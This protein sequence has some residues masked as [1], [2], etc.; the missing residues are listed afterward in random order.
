MVYLLHSICE[1]VR[2]WAEGC[3]CHWWLRRQASSYNGDV[4]G[5]RGKCS[6][7]ATQLDR[8]RRVALQFPSG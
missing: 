8:I 2:G 4:V 1:D 7:E 3:P 5:H 6:E